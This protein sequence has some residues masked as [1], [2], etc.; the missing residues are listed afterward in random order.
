[1]QEETKESLA[2]VPTTKQ[3]R[4][5]RREGRQSAEHSTFEESDEDMQ[6][7]AKE[8][9]S[10]S[11]NEQQSGEPLGKASVEGGIKEA[12]PTPYPRLISV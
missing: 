7:S 3:Y 6:E 12:R 5:P 1:M 11:A 8:D 4:L 10:I 9:E 2:L